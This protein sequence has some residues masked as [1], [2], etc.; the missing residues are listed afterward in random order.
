[1]KINIKNKTNIGEILFW[2]IVTILIVLGIY[3]LFRS[4]I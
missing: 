3:V 1:M 4:L 2:L